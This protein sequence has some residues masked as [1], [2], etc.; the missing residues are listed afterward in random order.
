MNMNADHERWSR[1][2]QLVDLGTDPESRRVL[3]ISRLV[4]RTRG[5]FLFSPLQLRWPANILD[6]FVACTK[7]PAFVAENFVRHIGQ[8]P[9]P[10]FPIDRLSNGP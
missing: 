1:V 3:L 10:A 2:A 9:F 7:L 8:V 5:W 4:A 6:D